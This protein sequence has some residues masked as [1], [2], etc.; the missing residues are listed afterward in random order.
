MKLRYKVSV[1]DPPPRPFRSDGWCVR[2]KSV[3]KWGLRKALRRLASEG[4]DRSVSIL[5]ESRDY[6][7]SSEE[8]AASLASYKRE[9]QTGQ[10]ELFS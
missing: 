4:Y 9:R 7:E 3:T 6:L 1:Y 2:Y 8:T 5:V 10:C